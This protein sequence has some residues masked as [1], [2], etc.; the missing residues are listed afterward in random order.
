LGGEPGT[1]IA[2]IGRGGRL[3]RQQHG[4]RLARELRQQFLIIL[5]DRIA[6]A[7]QSRDVC[8]EARPGTRKAQEAGVTELFRANLI[9]C[10]PRWLGG[11]P[12]A[13]RQA[14]ERG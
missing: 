12:H 2:R 4:G 8:C 5:A 13:R 1:G 7:Q 3:A 9:G 14:S 11:A 10:V 6:F